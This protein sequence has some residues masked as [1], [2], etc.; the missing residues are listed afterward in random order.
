MATCGAAGGT[1]IATREPSSRR[2]SRIGGAGR[3]EAERPCNLNGRSIQRRRIE[4]GRGLLP[5]FPPAFNPDVAGPVNH[6]LADVL[7]FEDRFQT[8]Q[9]R[10]QVVHASSVPICRAHIFPAA[11]ARQ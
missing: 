11:T 6:D 9:E 8:R 5:D 4:G 10:T 1:Q 7:I 2:A 3:I